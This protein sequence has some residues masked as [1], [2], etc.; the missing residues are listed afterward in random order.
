MFGPWAPS[1][2]PASKKP[3]RRMTG[4]GPPLRNLAARSADGGGDGDDDDDE[5]VVDVVD[6]VVDVDVVYDD[7]GAMNTPRRSDARSASYVA[8][9]TNS[10]RPVTSF[11]LGR[12]RTAE[13][14]FLIA[15]P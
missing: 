6:V 13:R 10:S 9:G 2:Y 15:G 1:G 12:Y 3:G 11:S 8:A 4:G 5:I 14:T 7:G